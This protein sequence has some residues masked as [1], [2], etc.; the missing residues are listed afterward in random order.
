M[1]KCQDQNQL[2]GKRVYFSL[3]PDG[4]ESFM[5][6]KHGRKWKVS[7]QEQRAEIA[8]EAEG[9]LK[10][11]WGSKPIPGEILPP[12]RLHLPTASPNSTAKI[13][14]ES[15]HYYVYRIHF[16]FKQPQSPCPQII[17]NQLLLPHV[18]LIFLFF[19]FLSFFWGGSGILCIE[20][21]SDITTHLTNRVRGSLLRDEWD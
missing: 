2:F 4:W 18:W 7:W 20:N 21:K 15:V 6:R 10:V 11:W 9:E 19:F 16:S 17:Q 13:G 8:H 12:A 14:T 1:I 5:M 3:P